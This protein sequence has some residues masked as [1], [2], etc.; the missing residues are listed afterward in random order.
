[1]QF[2]V[3]PL[4]IFYDKNNSFLFC[5]YLQLISI[6][7]CCLLFFTM[8]SKGEPSSQDATPKAEHERGHDILYCVEPAH[9]KL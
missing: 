8:K 9:P 1:V 2:I 6:E 5:I 3:H 4:F 7:I